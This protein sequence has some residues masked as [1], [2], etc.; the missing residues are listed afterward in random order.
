M[1]HGI[2]TERREAIVGLTIVGPRGRTRN[3]E[4]TVDTG[5]DGYLTLPFEFITRLGLTFRRRGRAE[6]ADGDD[7]TFDVY[8]AIVIWDGRRRR[9]EIDEA[10]TAPLL[11]MELMDGCELNIKVRSGGR[12]RIR[13]LPKS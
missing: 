12:V 9:I 10:N 2:V 5:F 1:I 4:A 7:I 13:R 11:G 3:I 8:E 6:L